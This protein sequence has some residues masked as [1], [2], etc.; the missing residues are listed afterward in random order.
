M[1]LVLLK[2]MKLANCMNRICKEVKKLKQ[3]CNGCKALD[4]DFKF[5]KKCILGHEIE[6]IKYCLEFQ[7]LTSLWKNVKSR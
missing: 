3:N 5:G 7:C 1:P 4:S 6:Q 2:K